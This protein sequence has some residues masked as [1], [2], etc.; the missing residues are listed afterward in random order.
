VNAANGERVWRVQAPGKIRATAAV[1]DVK[2]VLGTLDGWVIALD[3]AT[4]GE[5]WRRDVKGPVTS[6]LTFIGGKL[7]IGTRGSVLAAL[8]PSSGETL[9]QESFW[10]SWVESS[11]VLGDDGIAFIG[12]SDLRRVTA[13]DSA[14]GRFV[15]RTDV[16]G[17]SWGRPVVT[18]RTVYV[19]SAGVMPY[20]IRH[21]AAFTALDR[22]TGKIRWRWPVAQPAGAMLWGFAAGATLDDETLVVGGL[23]G[24]LYAFPAR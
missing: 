23:D 6:G 8:D 2:V 9:W 12:S 3:R 14:D 5:L 16:F 21:V 20:E 10:G 18:D 11:P 4:G 17:W 19:A 22:R 13:F 1:H 7:V 24:T 15:W